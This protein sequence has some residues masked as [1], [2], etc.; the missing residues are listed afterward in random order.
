MAILAFKTSLLSPE[1]PFTCGSR[2]LP[3]WF[4]HSRS[5]LSSRK[6]TRG[7][8]KGQ[9]SSQ[10]LS[11]KCYCFHARSRSKKASLYENW[12]HYD[13]WNPFRVSGKKKTRV[14][15]HN[16]LHLLINIILNTFHNRADG[17]CVCFFFLPHKGYNP[18]T[19]K[20]VKVFKRFEVCK[21]IYEQQDPVLTLVAAVCGFCV[22][23]GIPYALKFYLKRCFTVST[24]SLR[25]K[26]SI[27]F[28]QMWRYINRSKLA[29]STNY[30]AMSSNNNAVFTLQRNMHHKIQKCVE[31]PSNWL[32][33]TRKVLTKKTVSSK[34]AKFTAEET[35]WN[36]SKGQRQI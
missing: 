12:D 29:K 25:G 18:G 32:K 10:Q 30:P 7:Y 20:L 17:V 19:Q 5:D 2:A 4:L 36:V 35:G 1:L 34:R 8:F 16:R 24:G 22:S 3:F 21:S 15:K 9:A 31:S 13:H 23:K 14:D 11:P 27:Y 6:I 28:C 26:G 33:T